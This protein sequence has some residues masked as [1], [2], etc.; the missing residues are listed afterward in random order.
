MIFQFFKAP[1][2]FLDPDV[3]DH[4]SSLG[5]QLIFPH[6][7]ADLCDVFRLGALLHASTKFN[8]PFARLYKEVYA[9]LVPVLTVTEAAQ[10]KETTRQTIYSAIAGDDIDATDTDPPQVIVNAK[11]RQWRQRQGGRAGRSGRPKK[12]NS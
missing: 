3:I 4:L 11:F 1:E 8:V 9:E 5:R 10:E 6:P 12:K 7:K 2:S